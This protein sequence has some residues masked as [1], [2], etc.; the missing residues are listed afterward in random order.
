MADARVAVK[1][2]PGIKHY[3]DAKL[4]DADQQEWDTLAAAVNE[5]VFYFQS[6]RNVLM[7]GQED[8]LQSFIKTV[9]RMVALFDLLSRSMKIEIVGHAD[10]TGNEAYNQVI[11]RRRAQTFADFLAVA[12]I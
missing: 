7:P 4:A 9:K 8:K 5:S 3:D 6:G 10:R 11:S 1:S 12:R 2:L